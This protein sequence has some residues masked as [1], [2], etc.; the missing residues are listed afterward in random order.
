MPLMSVTPNPHN[1]FFLLA[2][3]VSAVD[4]LGSVAPYQVQ[5][6]CAIAL[7]LLHITVTFLVFHEGGFVEHYVNAGVWT[8]GVSSAIMSLVHAIF[9]ILQHPAELTLLF[10]HLCLVVLCLLLS[11][12]VLNRNTSRV[13]HFLDELKEERALF[14]TITTPSMAI[15]YGVIGFSSIHELCLDWSFFKQAVETWQRHAMLWY[16]FA[17]FTAIYPEEQTTT[18]QWIFHTVSS[19]RLKGQAAECIR[20]QA[21][22]IMHQREKTLSKSLSAKLTVLAKQQQP[23]KHLLRHVWDVVIQGNI[24]ELEG[25]AKRAIRSVEQNDADFT[26]LFRRFPNNRYVAKAYTAFL[27]SLTTDYAR[28]AAMRDKTHDLQRGIIVNM[29]ET[30]ELG[31][32]AFRA[33]PDRARRKRELAVAGTTVTESQVDGGDFDDDLRPDLDAILTIRYRI[34]ELPVPA[35]T[36]AR[37]LRIGILLLFCCFPIIFALVSISDYASDLPDPLEFLTQI[38][39]LNMYNGQIAALT[40]RRIG[41][42]FNVFTIPTDTSLFGPPPAALGDSWDTA[43]QLRNALA[44]AARTIE[45][46]AAFRSFKGA[47]EAR[48]AFFSGTVTYKYHSSVTNVTTNVI[49]LQSAFVETIVGVEGFAQVGRVL[50]PYVVNTSLVLNVVGNLIDV[51][52]SI[53]VI[54]GMI[55]EYLTE[56][57][58]NMELYGRMAIGVGIPAIIAIMAASFFIQVSWVRG[59]KAEAYRCLISLPKSVVSELAQGLRNVKLTKEGSDGIEAVDAHGQEENMLKLFNTAASA[60]HTLGDIWW[61]VI[62]NGAIGVTQIVALIVIILFVMNAADEIRLS[63]P[64]AFYVCDTFTGNAVALYGLERMALMD[65]P[66]RI[67][68]HDWIETRT[69]ILSRLSKGRSAYDM[70]T[71]GDNSTRPFAALGSFIDKAN[72]Y[73]Y[74]FPTPSTD[75]ELLS[76]YPVDV[77][78]TMLEPVVVRLLGLEGSFNINEPTIQYLWHTF[79]SLIYS[80][81]LLPMW[82][83]ILPSTID[84]LDD[85]M[86]TVIIIAVVIL[87]VDFLVEVFLWYHLGRV[88]EHIRSVLRLMLGC[89]SD[90]LTASPKI[91]NVVAG[92]FSPARSDAINRDTE[93]LES[94]YV[95]FPDAVMCTDAE[96]RIRSANPAAIALLVGNDPIG[97]TLDDFFKDSAFSGIDPALLSP[98]REP[99]VLDGITY[100]RCE[101]SSCVHLQVTIA[102]GPRHTIVYLK[103]RGELFECDSIIERAR[104]ECDELLSR[105]LPTPLIRKFQNEGKRGSNF[106]VVQ[107]ASIVFVSFHEFSKWSVSVSPEVAMEVL[108]EVFSRFD[109][110][111]N[112]KP[113]MMKVKTMGDVYMAAG[114]IFYDVNCGHEH[115]TEAL[116]FGLESVAA[117]SRLNEERNLRLALRVGQHIGGPVFVGIIG[118]AFERDNRPALDEIIKPTFEIIGPAVNKALQTLDTKGIPGLVVISREVFQRID[119]GQFAIVDR[120]AVV[121]GNANV[122]DDAT[123]VVKGRL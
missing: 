115:V 31:L 83:S 86:A 44:L 23:T 107:V 12:Q 20:S 82:E 8:I 43:V 50:E 22:A 17:K 108:N 96:R 89:R 39:L 54:R 42:E 88:R 114:D 68:I 27:K 91:M 90:I 60:D 117:L 25:A 92:D 85:E 74:C 110:I 76:C 13:L 77:L 111:I 2:L 72:K 4:G 84:F 49:S 79:L 9:I 75:E 3:V 65:T 94:V 93:F 21:L 1:R 33:L 14:R 106:T 34:D 28:W 51:G 19:L 32:K 26:H 69:G 98:A 64:H 116:M 95:G 36:A 46:A 66:Y 87:L 100:D 109:A 121:G 10:V 57:N 30:H 104:S 45:N 16:V 71:F 102:S 119:R 78:T 24:G 7:A 97:E 70:L 61:K 37:R 29:D 6:A 55:F 18:L 103:E 80:Q 48:D 105:I 56:S 59:D 35:I 123:Y 11:R 120:S 118:P 122:N 73:R 40:V 113:S 47:D 63:A 15:R 99:R 53:D 38:S 101:S 52:G 58:R 67:L 81:F 41:E 62:G 112:G 5:F